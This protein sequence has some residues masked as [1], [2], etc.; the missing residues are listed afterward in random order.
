MYGNNSENQT[1]LSFA[2]SESTVDFLSSKGGILD[3]HKLFGGMTKSVF[4]RIAVAHA[5]SN[6]PTKE[7]LFDL[8][9]CSKNTETFAKFCKSYKS[10]KGGKN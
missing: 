1:A 5:L 7:Q 4:L 3:A 6:P 8:L 9:K 10:N 2:V